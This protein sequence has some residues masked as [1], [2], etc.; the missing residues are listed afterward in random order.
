MLVQTGRQTYPADHLFTSQRELACHTLEL[1][2]SGEMLRRVG[3][4]R[5]FRPQRNNTLFLIPPRTSYALQ[6]RESGVEIWLLFSPAPEFDDCMQWPCGDF[7]VPE[8]RVPRTPLGREILQALEDTHQYMSSRLRRRERLAENALERLLLL[9]GRLHDETHATYDERIRSA[10]DVI[11]GT[12][13]APLSVDSLAQG[14]NLS[15]SR[16]AHLFREETGQSP[17]RYVE[18]VRLEQAQLLLLRT[19]LQ[20]KEIAARV[21]F[22]DP[23]YFSARFRRHFGR[24][25]TAWR[26]APALAAPAEDG[27]TP[28]GSA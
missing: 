15:S 28:V 14:V 26:N 3:R 6:G 11:H 16:F 19:D 9:L 23:Y 7:G 2:Y 5:R 8:L 1:T 25:P 13:Q 4:M 22:E 18:H 20:V 21:G 12:Y 24:P 17:I 27:A 10:L